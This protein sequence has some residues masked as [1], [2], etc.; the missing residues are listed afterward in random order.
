MAHFSLLMHCRRCLRVA[1]V[2]AAAWALAG[3][4]V[5]TKIPIGSTAGF[6]ADLAL[7]GAW[8][9]PDEKGAAYLVFLKN[10]D[11]SLSVISF[12][13]KDSQWQRYSVRTSKLGART[14]MNVR[15][16]EADGAPAEDELTQGIIPI[17]YSVDKTSLTLNL[18]DEDR[19]KAAIRSATIAGM[20]EPGRFGDAYITAGPNA[21]DAFMRTP[22]GLALFDKHPISLRRIN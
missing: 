17:L 6:T 4:L 13:S 5:F 7:L 12:D 22:A 10:K 21:L 9:V 19:T 8:Q 3:C 15:E 2:L 1:A 11:G 18:L 20:I 16:I 14:F